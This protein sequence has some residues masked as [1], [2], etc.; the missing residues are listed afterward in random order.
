MQRS[1]HSGRRP[2]L[3]LV[4]PSPELT[5]YIQVA[6]RSEGPV[7]VLGCGTGRLAWE[8]AQRGRRVVAVEPSE[9]LLRAAESRRGTEPASVS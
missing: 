3:R 4:L 5:F 9:S 7:L 1:S 2:P 8:L 6:A